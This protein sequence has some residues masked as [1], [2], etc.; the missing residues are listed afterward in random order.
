MQRGCCRWC[1]RLR[2]ACIKEIVLQQSLTSKTHD[3]N[4]LKQSDGVS[5]P[6]IWHACMQHST[7]K[8]DKVACNTQCLPLTAAPEATSSC[9]PHAAILRSHVNLSIL[10]ERPSVPALLV[11]APVA[12]LHS[13]NVGQ[14]C[15]SALLFGA[16]LV[17]GSWTSACAFQHK[18]TLGVL[19]WIITTSTRNLPTVCCAI[20]DAI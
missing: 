20:F 3:H 14:Q 2:P 5:L 17:L 12:M 1:S 18:T 11:W 16:T 15:L 9:C 19:A 7:R 8:C 6:T 13:V 10:A 4:R